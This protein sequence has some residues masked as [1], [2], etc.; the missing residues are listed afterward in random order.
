VYL[1]VYICIQQHYYFIGL[2]LSTWL[3][4]YD[5]LFCVRYNMYRGI[6]YSVVVAGNDEKIVP[7]PL[8]CR[9][10]VRVLLSSTTIPRRTRNILQDGLSLCSTWVRYQVGGV[11]YMEREREQGTKTKMCSSFLEDRRKWRMERNDDVYRGV[12]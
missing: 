7:A 9:V 8:R 6:Y 1:F 4:A 10:C 11:L 3:L 12:P 2:I 5:R